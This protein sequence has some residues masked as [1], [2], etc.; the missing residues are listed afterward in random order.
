[1]RGKK[2]V[3]FGNVGLFKYT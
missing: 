1:L 2:K 3:A